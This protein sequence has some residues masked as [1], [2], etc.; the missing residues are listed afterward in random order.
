MIPRG[1][2]RTLG[3][4]LGGSF[5]TRIVSFLFLPF[6][7]RQVDPTHYGTLSLATAFITITTTIMGLGLRQL[8]SLEYF[9]ATPRERSLLIH[10]IIM[11]YTAIALPIVMSAWLLR[12]LIIRFIFFTMLTETQFLALL[13]TIGAFFY[14]ELRYQIMQYEQTI[15]TLTLL[16]CIVALCNAVGTFFVLTH[17]NT[18]I[19][20]ILWVQAVVALGAAINAGY[21]FAH[22]HLQHGGM[23]LHPPSY[24]LYYGIPFIPGTLASWML[25]SADRWLLGYFGTL[26]D[27]GIYAVADIAAQLFYALILQSWAACYLPYIMR[28]YQTHKPDILAIEKRNERTM[29][30]ALFILA[31]FI[32][33]GYPLAHILAPYLLPPAYHPALRYM[34]ILI[35]GQ[36]FLLGSYFASAFIQ[37]ARRTSFLVIALFIPALFNVILNALLIPRAGIAGC[38]VATMLAY[39]LYFLIT[40]CYNKKIR[41]TFAFSR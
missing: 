4:Y 25:A 34:I 41:R 28:Q 3:I 36:L 1:V 29:W 35:Y 37:Y 40:Y 17:T 2:I 31:L 27:V 12:S 8:L 13:I 24:Y 5:L 33:C 30:Y 39:A 26:H 9:H 18:L 14:N 16:Q 7:M 6:I 38:A 19:S 11:I 22:H 32:L 20:G 15:G 10:D 23:Q 21:Y